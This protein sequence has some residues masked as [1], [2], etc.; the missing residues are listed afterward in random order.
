MQKRSLIAISLQNILREI[1][2]SLLHKEMF[3]I[4]FI[5]LLLYE[6]PIFRQLKSIFPCSKAKNRTC[7]TLLTKNIRIAREYNVC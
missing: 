4:F 1:K 7:K 2:A 3:T 6:E 5:I